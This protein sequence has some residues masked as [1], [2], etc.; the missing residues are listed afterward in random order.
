MRNM[1]ENL[2]CPLWALSSA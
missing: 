2:S 1:M